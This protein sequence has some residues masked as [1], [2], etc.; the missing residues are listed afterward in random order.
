MRAVEVVPWR[1]LR[2]ASQACIIAGTLMEQSSMWPA[3][4]LAF[5]R[6]PAAAVL[7]HYEI[8]PCHVVGC[9]KP[10]PR[11]FDRSRRPLSPNPGWVCYAEKTHGSKVLPHLSPCRSPQVRL[12]VSA[13]RRL[14]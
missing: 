4:L 6:R 9:V 14:S 12:T 2:A 7:I 1:V 5:A 13:A 3:L 8:G 10:D 11:L